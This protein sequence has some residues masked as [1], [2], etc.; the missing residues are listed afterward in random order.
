[1]YFGM[2]EKYRIAVIPA[3]TGI[4]KFLF[5]KR[6]G[7]PITTSG[8]TN[9]YFCR[10]P[11]CLNLLTGDMKVLRNT[12]RYIAIF[13]IILA[14]VPSSVRADIRSFIPKITDYAG[15]LTVESSYES[16]GNKENNRGLERSDLYMREIVELGATGYVFH[17]RFIT[18]FLGLSG[19]I[20]EERF[21]SGGSSQ[22]ANW[23]IM[24][25]NEYE[26]RAMIL[27]EHPYNLELF[28]RRSEP[29]A[30]GVLS[31]QFQSVAY[32]S[33]AIFRY[34]KKPY[35]LDVYY[36]QNS[37]EYALSNYTATKY[38]LLG[39]YFK[40]RVGGNTYSFA[41]SY[42][43]Q[44]TGSAGFTNSSDDASVSNT[45]AYKK[46][47]LSSALSFHRA[48]EEGGL[49][50]L[51]IASKNMAWSERGSIILPWNFRADLLY[52]LTKDWITM[53]EPP[54]SGT[55]IAD[56][57]N[58]A[59]LS[60]T[61]KLYESL[62]STYN[63]GYTSS[64]S[65]SGQGTTISNGL[66]FAYA[67]NI[68]KGK[69]R[70]TFSIGTSNVDNTG[71]LS[72][73]NEPHNAVSVPF[74]RITLNSRDVDT[75][76]IFVF[77]KNPDIPLELYLLRENID[78][79]II[80]SG[81]N[82]EMEMVNLPSPL[83]VPGT[84]DF[85]V[86]Y[87]MVNQDTSFQMRTLNSTVVLELFK[88]MFVP[89]WNHSEN[90]QTGTQGVSVPL[91]ITSDVFGFSFRRRPFSASGQYQVTTSNVN[92]SKGWRVELAYLDSVLG[93]TQVQAGAQYS[94]TSYPQDSFM[95]G[96][97][98]T[99]TLLGLSAGI[100]QRIPKRS[101]F[102]Y[103]GGAYTQEKA[104]GQSTTYSLNSSFVWAVGRMTINAGSTFSV[105][106]TE[107][108]DTKSRRTDQYYYL[109]VKRKLF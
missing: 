33:G 45:I 1:M 8:M 100:Q 55:K 30:K 85:T 31:S 83:L 40:E 23:Q 79:I 10:R 90:S 35:F 56:T 32:S 76:T 58:T 65:D 75:A 37:N 52:N 64:K 24:N 63:L 77:V 94:S 13:M 98:Y 61:H 81:N 103:V 87:S 42:E 93:I 53:G 28:L 96:I 5:L 17:P 106:E 99:D 95:G 21:D 3:K 84:Y 73:A 88:D 59:A 86:S 36:V 101:M 74:G 49:Q 38:G 80:R 60:I 78:Y 18:F 14:A 50:R 89:F 25:S 43:H 107:I 82:I 72:V 47:N 4:H 15:Y 54:L 102:I 67:K 46:V 62:I 34:K 22:N 104:I 26:A 2:R 105:A 57:V 9:K 6:I 108:K 11:G 91:N 66:G 20:K 12:V 39:T 27:P 29:L 44:D 69:L 48:D 68:P 19:G 92:P 71:T 109:S 16:H 41:V 7:F 70:V 97:G 51:S